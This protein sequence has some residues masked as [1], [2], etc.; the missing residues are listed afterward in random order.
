[1]KKLQNVLLYGGLIIFTEVFAFGQNFKISVTN[2]LGQKSFKAQEIAFK[3][4]DQIPKKIELKSEIELFFEAFDQCNKIYSD[5][6]ESSARVEA[7]L[8]ESRDVFMDQCL[9]SA[10]PNILKIINDRNL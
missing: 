9:K 7:G 10:F 2:N 5:P 8:D 6:E 1:V 4:I 3:I